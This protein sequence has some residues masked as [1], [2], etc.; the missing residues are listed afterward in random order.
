MDNTAYITIEDNSNTSSLPSVL[1]LALNELGESSYMTITFK[2]IHPEYCVLKIECDDWQD[3]VDLCSTLTSI[4]IS[5]GIYSF[6]FTYRDAY[7][8]HE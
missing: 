4:L 2:E 1:D 5:E 6:T 3:G 8:I 7:S